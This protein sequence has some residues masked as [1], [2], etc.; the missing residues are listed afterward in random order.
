MKVAIKISSKEK[1]ADFFL[2]CMERNID[3]RNC[4]IANSHRY[5]SYAFFISTIDKKC[6][7]RSVEQLKQ[8]GYIIISDINFITD[9]A[10]A[11]RL[12]IGIEY[13]HILNQ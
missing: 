3:I 1:L 5:D 12:I 7:Y 10:G 13:D 11:H 8:D 6:Y 9:E 2:Y 4:V